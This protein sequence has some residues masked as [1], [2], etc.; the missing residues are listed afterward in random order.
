MD[1]RASRSER[2]CESAMADLGST[3]NLA[4]DKPAAAAADAEPARKT[5]NYAL[6]KVCVC[7]WLCV[8]VCVRGCVWLQLCGLALAS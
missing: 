6:V 7:V 8:C 2:V 3:N 4:A 5:Y 1:V